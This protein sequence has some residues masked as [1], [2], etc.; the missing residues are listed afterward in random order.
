MGASLSTVS[1]RGDALMALPNNHTPG[2]ICNN[3]FLAGPQ[4]PGALR[5][6]SLASRYA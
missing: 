1:V 5:P 6:F 3:L 2:L 4:A